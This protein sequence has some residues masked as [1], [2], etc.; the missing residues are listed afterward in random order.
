[1][2]EN[3][4]KQPTHQVVP[5][6]ALVVVVELLEAI[7]ERDPALANLV[8]ERLEKFAS[9]QVQIAQDYPGSI[10]LVQLVAKGLEDD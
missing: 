3:T 1:M 2:D 7:K 4:P 10:E 5:M 9:T 8:R 6:A